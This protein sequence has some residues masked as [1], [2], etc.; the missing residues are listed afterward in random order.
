[1]EA[2][3]AVWLKG[4]RSD[5]A[6]EGEHKGEHQRPKF[7][8]MFRQRAQRSSV[9]VRLLVREAAAP[10][11]NRST[12]AR[13]AFLKF[14]SANR[15][16]TFKEHIFV[17]LELGQCGKNMFLKNQHTY[18]LTTAKKDSI[19]ILLIYFLPLVKCQWWKINK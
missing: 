15:F 4:V 6:S 1:M 17:T 3:S 10:S 2:A 16:V 5:S 19:N 13:S 12:F 8:T 11:R 14:H 9:P 7:L 18:F